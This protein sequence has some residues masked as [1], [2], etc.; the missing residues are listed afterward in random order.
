[1]KKQTRKQIV[2]LFLAVSMML[3]GC[4]G[5]KKQEPQPTTEPVEETK[6]EVEIK[7]TPL[8]EE[9]SV[10]V[11][12]ESLNKEGYAIDSV[13]FYGEDSLLVVLKDEESKSMVAIYNYREG[14]FTKRAT[15][16]NEAYIDQALFC[17][18]GNIFLGTS[19]ANTFYYL[20]SDLN[21]IFRSTDLPNGYASMAPAKEGTYFYYL[22]T[23]EKNLYQYELETHESKEVMTIDSSY[24]HLAIRDVTS[25]GN[26]VVGTYS[27]E[28]GKLQTILIKPAVHR[29]L[30]MEGVG[31]NIITG[32][33]TIYLADYEKTANG[34]M[35]YF[36]IDNPRIL[37]KFYFDNKG[38]GNNFFVDATDGVLL[39]LKNNI[40]DAKEE[41][42]LT[43]QL[44]DLNKG[45]LTRST[46][47]SREQ[48]FTY[49]GYSA[50]GSDPVNDWFFYA[51]TAYGLNADHTVAYFTYFVNGRTSVMLW[52]LTK[53]AEEAKTQSGTAFYTN[54][55]ITEEDNDEYVEQL[56]EKYGV[57]IYIRNKVVKFFPDFAVNA[58]YD[59]ET[60][61]EALKEV[62]KLLSRFPEGFFK[63]LSYGNISGL[64]IYLCG[65]LVQGSDSGIQ[66]PG[67][68][69]LQYKGKQ[70]IVMDATYPSG[71]VSSI[72]HEIMH[73]IDARLDYM[74][75]T[76]KKV[77]DSIF[78][79]WNKLNPKGYDYKYS[80]VDPEGVE[81]N[82]YNNGAYTPTDEKSLDDVNHIYYLDYYSNTFPIEDR[83]RI[84]EYLMNADTELSYEFKSKHIKKK[85]KLLCE[86]IR[87]AMPSIPENEVMYWEKFLQ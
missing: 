82:A 61:N 40:A 6:K 53:E 16:D 57:T 12:D 33:N 58:L 48:L 20:D 78:T 4:S 7:G 49:T 21:V 17:D 80:Y 32:Q 51:P 46:N 15:I 30:P 37:H 18:N 59:E 64:E 75:N 84:F 81:Y 1:M 14:T 70:M 55:A 68:F 27:D 42:V 8:N 31:S 29:L 86:M 24:E 44:Y 26:Y 9:G 35:E 2:V 85:A 65:T 11:I 83:A 10:Y 39:S 54:N 47:V 62:E 50:K 45:M 72:S 38:E 66:S 52:D 3:A 71:L 69:A 19:W 60:T 41:N 73:A 74:V 76:K 22:D 77:N 87:L 43:L 36:Q 23:A 63:N 25:D 28:D 34:Y 56:N 13:Y 79:R 67:G 5:K